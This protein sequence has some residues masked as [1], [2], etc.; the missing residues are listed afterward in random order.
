[1][2][3]GLC[4]DASK[5]NPL[6]GLE[7]GEYSSRQKEKIRQE[8]ELFMEA[9]EKL[10]Q[11]LQ[12]VTQ[13]L[14]WPDDNWTDGQLQKFRELI[15]CILQLPDMPESFFQI[16]HL[17][18]FEEVLTPLTTAGEQRDKIDGELLKKFQTTL[19]E[20]PASEMLT[21]WNLS[22]AKWFLPRYFGQKKVKKNL[23]AFLKTGV[24]TSREVPQILLDTRVPEK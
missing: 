22:S 6:Y 17:S 14:P 19:L 11:I 5:R 9:R 1:M 20:A 7:P 21:E 8:L 4:G 15:D 10:N 12:Q 2:A 3:A 23:Y 18:D 24:I 16:Q 13:I